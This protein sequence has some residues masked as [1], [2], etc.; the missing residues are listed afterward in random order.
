M[1]L[2]GTKEIIVK[3]LG[4]TAEYLGG[5]LKNYAEKGCQNISRVFSVAGRRLGSRISEPGQ[6][7]PK[8][9][10]EVLNQGYF[11]EDQLAA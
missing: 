4:P 7:P 9:L 1:A 2:F 10:K 5:G 6:I 8:V 3:L 11:C